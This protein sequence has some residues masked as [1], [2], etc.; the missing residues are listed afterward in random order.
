M[1]NTSRTAKSFMRFVVRASI[2]TEAGNRMIGD[3][4]FLENIENYM[5]STKAED[6][7]FFES[8]GQRSMTFIIDMQSTDQM[9]SIAE[10]LFMMGANVE[11]HPAMKVDDLKKAIKN[12]PK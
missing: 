7:Y 2:P 3:P 5:K 8:G 10:P 12:A 6:A 1:L 11:F 4:S 9:A